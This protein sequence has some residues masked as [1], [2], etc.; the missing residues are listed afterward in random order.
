[1]PRNTT[2][3]LRP[4]GITG[5]GL[6]LSIV[7]KLVT[8]MGGKIEVKSKLGVGTKVRVA[9]PVEKAPAEMA[10]NIS[11]KIEIREEPAKARVL[12]AEDN[13]INREIAARILEACGAEVS[14]VENGAE[15]LDFVMGGEKIDL[16]FMDIQMPIMDGLEATRRIRAYEKENGLAHLP[17]VALTANAFDDA[18]KKAKEAG[19]DEYLTKPLEPEKNKSGA[20]EVWK[21]KLKNLQ[22]MSSSRWIRT[23]HFC[24]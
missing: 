10:A 16:V 23:A 22:K 7:K 3:P 15:A 5:T 24:C 17:I 14:M 9:I 1:L 20:R 6:G 2:N 4:K 11:N 19:V 8:L 21:W 13:E 12:V 18:V